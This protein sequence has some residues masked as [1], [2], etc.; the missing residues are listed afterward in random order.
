MQQPANE[1]RNH[2]Q[3]QARGGFGDGD[4]YEQLFQNAAMR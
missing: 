3:R 2:E 4:E 1:G